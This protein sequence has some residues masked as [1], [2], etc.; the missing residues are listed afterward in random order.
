MICFRSRPQ[1]AVSVELHA[2]EVTVQTHGLD[3]YGR[4][5]GDVLLLDGTN[6]NHAL[7]KDS[8]CWW[9]RTYAPWDTVLEG[10]EIEAR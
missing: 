8:L 9:F 3:R 7:V 6:V 2:E 1:Y 10:L 5:L 4:T